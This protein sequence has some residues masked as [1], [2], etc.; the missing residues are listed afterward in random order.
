[1]TRNRT[2]V[3]LD[4]T[5]DLCSVAWSDGVNWIERSESAGQRHSAL[6]ISMVDSILREAGAHLSDLSEIAFG[7]GP[8]SFTGLRIAC[9]VAQGLA[10]GA[11]LP[12]RAVSSLL[13]LAQAAREDA[14]VAALDARMNEVYWAAYRR[15]AAGSA[16]HT[17]SA[18]AVAPVA[19]VRWPA[20]ARWFG[21]GNGFSA[22]PALGAAMPSLAG[23][24]PSLRV[25]ARAIAELALA[26]H[27][28]LGAADRA[29]PHYIRDKVALTT[30]ERAGAR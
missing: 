16:W 28:V 26:D 17:A 2:V 21:A 20:G 13:A 11:Q 5:A 15:Q 9:G 18:P 10:L 24:D 1:M 25:T 30:L 3:A 29:F 4:A 8:G 14:V 22:Y 7:A 12:V 27:G 19:A 6:I 23:C